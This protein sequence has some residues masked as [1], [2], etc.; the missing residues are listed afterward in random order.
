MLKINLK[1]SFEPPGGS[2]KVA[3]EILGRVENIMD[4]TK[5]GNR[6][7]MNRGRHFPANQ[8]IKEKVIVPGFGYA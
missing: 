3:Q 8:V 2:R 4:C 1:S 5:K 6:G 7:S